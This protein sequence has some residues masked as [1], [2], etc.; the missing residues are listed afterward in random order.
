VQFANEHAFNPL[1]ASNWYTVDENKAL[2]HR[3]EY[4]INQLEQIVYFY[5]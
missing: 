5:F 4:Q 3:V 1:V 2:A